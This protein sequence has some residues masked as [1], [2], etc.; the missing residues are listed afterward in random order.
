MYQK[1]GSSLFG[2]VE[3]SDP[4]RF[5]AVAAVRT[6]DG[7]QIVDPVLGSTACAAEVVLWEEEGKNTLLPEV[8]FGSHL[9]SVADFASVHTKADIRRFR[10]IDVGKHFP[11]AA[12]VAGSA[13][14]HVI[15]L[16]LR[17][18]GGKRSGE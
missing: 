4:Q 18:E 8:P 14:L 11:R 17:R 7:L 12:T 10:F 16:P 5:T 2:R 6:H 13:V 9:R 1:P 3:L 15:F